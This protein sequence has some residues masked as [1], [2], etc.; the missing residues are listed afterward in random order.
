LLSAGLPPDARFRAVKEF[1]ATRGLSYPV[2]LKPDVGERGTGVA[3]TCSDQDLCLYFDTH[4][5]DTIVQRYVDG[6]EF[7]IFYY[8]YPGGEK[9]HIFSITEKRFPEVTGD[10]TSTITELVLR[11]ER[12]V[13]LADLYLGRLKRAV[14]EVPAEGEVVRLPEL[15]S[16]CRGA[17]FLNGASLETEALRAATDSIARSHAGFYFGRFDVR[18]PSIQELKS[19]RFEVLEPNG[20]SAEATHIY[21]PAVSLLEAYRVMFRQWRIAFEIGAIN[22][23]EGEQPMRFR[24]IVGLLRGR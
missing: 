12:A 3:I 10:G 7:G 4:A 24:E 16:H 20:V 21:D 14:D 22:R 15:G 11:D 9:G 6:L 19:G 13:C 5:S 23:R 2:V 8:R 18:S 1:L 17:V